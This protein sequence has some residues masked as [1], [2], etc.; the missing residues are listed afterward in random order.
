[1]AA[2]NIIPQTNVRA[3][4]IRDTLASHGGTVGNDI[5][6]FFKE[7][8]KINKWSFYKPYSYPKDFGITDTEIYSIDCGMTFNVYP[9][10]ASTVAALNTG[11]VWR[12]NLPTGGASSPYRLGDFRG[13]NP[14]TKEWFGVTVHGGA[15]A[16]TV[17]T[18]QNIRDVADR[19]PNFK[20]QIPAS[21]GLRGEYFLTLLFYDGSGTLHS[22]GLA[23][24]VD[25][26]SGTNA[27]GG[28][29]STKIPSGSYYAA[30]GVSS[31]ATVGSVGTM[32][33]SQSAWTSQWDFKCLSDTWGAF[34]VTSAAD[35]YN[36]YLDNTVVTA[37]PNYTVY[38][39]GAGFYT[40]EGGASLTVTNSNSTALTYKV[41][42]TLQ[43]G[44]ESATTTDTIYVGKSSSATK[45]V[46]CPTIMVQA[47][48]ARLTVAVT[49]ESA[50]TSKSW[51]GTISK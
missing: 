31:F 35:L 40:F 3:E 23:D 44:K 14:N 10:P 29:L 8:A 25:V 26:V 49:F 12:Y 15:Q 30:L 11:T 20:G 2:L 21:G 32:Y 50:T 5:A 19:M 6:S 27:Y 33:S 41:V 7:A 37:T 17:T 9:T 42:T 24:M 45:T 16:V 48:S 1:M 38:S 13:Y 28:N 46:S 22:V 43:S 51:S 39:E 4:D 36:G 18:P 47:T 34:S